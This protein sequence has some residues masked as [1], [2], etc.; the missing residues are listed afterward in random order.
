MRSHC[1]H[2][3]LKLER[4]VGFAGIEEEVEGRAV[5]PKIEVNVRGV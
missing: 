4:E 2:S 1:H 5:R 3:T